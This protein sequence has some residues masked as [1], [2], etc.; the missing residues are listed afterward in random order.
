M[1]YTI[2]ILF[3]FF[4]LFLK[5]QNELNLENNLTG[6]YSQSRSSNLGL[7]FNGLNGFYH[8]HLS[9]DFNTNYL[10]KLN[11]AITE[12]EFLHRS[13]IDYDKGKWDAFITHQYNYSLI[14]KIE[15]DNWFG[16]GFGL[17]K[18]FTSS[19]I[20]LSY[21]FMY[22]R[23]DYSSSSVEEELRH[24]LRLKYK[25]DTKSIGFS[26]E[27]YYQPNIFDLSDYIILGTSK[28]VILPEHKINFIIQDVINIRSESDITTLHNLTIG[29]GVK[30][31][32][33]FEK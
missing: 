19:K 28:I 10:L 27:F 22:Q 31:N 29:L 25:V 24:S 9:F 17:K 11:D 23:A 8:N 33:K 3:L 15:S 18:K 5:S 7:N 2:S 4:F 32:K 12:N 21:A 26:T 16:I 20:S 30:L 14:R 1:K 13:T 6:I